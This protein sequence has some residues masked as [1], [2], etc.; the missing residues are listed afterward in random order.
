MIELRTLIFLLSTESGRYDE[1]L[2]LFQPHKLYL[3]I[4]D[5]D[6]YKPDDWEIL[7]THVREIKQKMRDPESAVEVRIACLENK[8]DFSDAF[9]ELLRI[10]NEERRR[11][12]KVTVAISGGSRI[13]ISAAIIAA[14]ITRSEIYY[15]SFYA[16]RA[17][18]SEGTADLSELQKDLVRIPA[19][20]IGLPKRT[21]R[22]ILMALLERGADSRFS[23]MTIKEL[24]NHIGLQ[25]IVGEQRSKIMKRRGSNPI[26][27]ATVMLGSALKSLSREGF[28]E[29]AAPEA[30]RKSI[31]LTPR[32]YLMAMT[33]KTLEG[34]SHTNQ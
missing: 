34:N 25:N 20:P 6:F 9:I 1:F 21:H 13:L 27:A 12:Y 16:K 2:S 17:R 15:M 7:R 3:V 10:M 26:H 8:V 24:L 19:F 14:S 33:V 32:G 31:R 18:L 4:K 30:R 5:K 22:H 28:V 29:I 11:G 23:L